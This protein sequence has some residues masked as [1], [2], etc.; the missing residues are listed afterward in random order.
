MRKITDFPLDQL[1]LYLRATSTFGNP[2]LVVRHSDARNRRLQCGTLYTRE[3]QESLAAFD[4]H[5]QALKVKYDAL[6]A[7][8]PGPV[9]VLLWTELPFSLRR[10]KPRH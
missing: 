7:K 3:P 9:Q 5:L 4:D 10:R 2:A 6:M 8:N 1:A